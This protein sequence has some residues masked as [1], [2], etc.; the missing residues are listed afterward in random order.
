MSDTTIPPARRCFAVEHPDGS[1]ETVVFPP[2]VAEGLARF[3]EKRSLEL[4][5]AIGV[6][7][8]VE[9]GLGVPEGRLPS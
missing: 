5:E 8:N 1:A 7:V 4:E 6:L 2:C 9:L 3:A